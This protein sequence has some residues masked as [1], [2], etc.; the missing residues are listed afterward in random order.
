MLER[1]IFIFRRDLRLS[2]NIGLMNAL[3]ES[4]QV[5]PIFI[6][7]ENQIT[8]KN[9]YKSNNAVQFMIESLDDL[10]DNLKMYKSALNYFYGDIN[11]ILKKLIKKYE[12]DGIFFNLDYTPY[13]TARD[14]NIKELCQTFNIT[15]KTYHDALLNE[16]HTVKSGSESIYL[17]FTPYYNKAIQKSVD[18]PLKLLNMDRLS[19]NSYIEEKDTYNKDIYKFYKENDK[20]AVN[21]GRKEAIK[22]LKILLTLKDYNE[23]RNI[24]HI[25]TS[26]LSAYNKFGC[27]SIREV[28]YFG[29]KLNP[30]IKTNDFIRQLYW[31]DFYYNVAYEHPETVPP[32]KKA[33]KEKYDDI[34]WVSDNKLLNA[35][36]NGQ[37]GYPIVDACMTQLN[38]TGYIH[39][40][41]RL[42]V[43]SFLVKLMGIDWKE[44]DIYFSQ[45]LVDH[46]P[47]VNSSNWQWLASSGVDSQAYYRIFNPWLQSLNYD[48]DCIYIKQ[49]IPVLKNVDNKDIHI[50]YDSC[51]LDKYKNIDYISPIIDYKKQKEKSLIMYTK[52]FK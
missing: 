30:K 20:I 41:G 34:K 37:T 29:L 6:F 17:K 36:K 51:K 46:D 10:N 23:D 3:K 39:G 12:I 52:I 25:R 13:S 15:C 18:K 19:K 14:N 45:M 4:K 27:V 1:S 31:R 50:W 47:I 49:W 21:G 5:I 44:G 9:K 40:R 32:L 16:I 28:Y 43:G 2:D 38:E 8:S 24:L 22:H 42:I 35:W 26:M 11:D 7:N 48:R 33:L